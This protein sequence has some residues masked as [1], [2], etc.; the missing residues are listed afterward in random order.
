MMRHGC[1]LPWKKNVGVEEGDTMV[2]GWWRV[3]R[4]K[5][6]WSMEDRE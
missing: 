2:G 1:I 3:D 6:A 5:R 4:K